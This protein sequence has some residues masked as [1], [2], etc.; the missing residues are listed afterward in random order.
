[1]A[2]H[3]RSAGII[4]PLPRIPPA[5]FTHTL[6]CGCVPLAS[7]CPQ[8]A[9]LYQFRGDSAADLYRYAEHYRGGWSS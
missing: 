1:M 9:L 3:P 2:T 4:P 8:A 6:H 5:T 7:R